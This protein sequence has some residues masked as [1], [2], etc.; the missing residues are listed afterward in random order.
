[1]AP[2]PPQLNVGTFVGERRWKY[3]SGSRV[4]SDAV[5]DGPINVPSY[6]GIKFAYTCLRQIN[7][8]R[9]LVKGF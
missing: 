2:N 3:L 7:F 9:M 1:M 6:R 4:H 8:H 5:D